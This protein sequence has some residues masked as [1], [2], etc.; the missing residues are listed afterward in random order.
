M[1]FS[2]VLEWNA[3]YNIEPFGSQRDNYHAAMTAHIL[4]NQNSK[5]PVH[6]SEFMYQD[7][8]SRREAQERR[9]IAALQKRSKQ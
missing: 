1:S 2:E 7:E 9:M 6:F 5:K 4:A 3:Y 8:R